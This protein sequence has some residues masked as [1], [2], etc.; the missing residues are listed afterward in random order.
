MPDTPK[1]DERLPRSSIL[2]GRARF[3]KVRREGKRCQGRFLVLNWLLADARQMAVI[4]PKA[5][6]NA[7]Q[8]NAVKRKAREV[9]RRLQGDLPLMLRSIWI[10]RRA[11]DVS[12]EEV[13]SEM[14]SLY[15]KAGFLIQ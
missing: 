7:V 12:Y 5:V 6:G 14:T 8:R 1:R 15:R 3:E 11:A 10:V 4:V 13:K 9:Y 2:R